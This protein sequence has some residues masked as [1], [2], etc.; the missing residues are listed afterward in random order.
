[1]R[2]GSDTTG[3]DLAVNLFLLPMHSSFSLFSILSYVY[4]PDVFYEVAIRL[5]QRCPTQ[6]AY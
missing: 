1:V 2:F 4:N 5:E 3:F 6:M